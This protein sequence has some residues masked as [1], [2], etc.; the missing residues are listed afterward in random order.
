MAEPQMMMTTTLAVTNAT[1]SKKKRKTPAQPAADH[2]DDAHPK[3]TNAPRVYKKCEHGR[4]KH[5]CRDCRG[6]S[7]CLHNRQK[8]QC[9]PCGGKSICIH[10]RIRS[11]CKDCGGGS[12]CIHNKVKSHCRACGGSKYCEHDKQKHR[13]KECKGLSLCHHGKV[14]YE[15]KACRGFGFCIHNRRKSQC[16]ECSG[17]I[18]CLHSKQKFRCTDCR[19]S[20]ICKHGQEKYRC[21]DCF[22]SSVCREHKMIKKNC[23]SC[24]KRLKCVEPCSNAG[25]LKIQCQFGCNKFLLCTG[26]NTTAVKKYGDRCAA[27]NTEKTRHEYRF[28]AFLREQA[29]AGMIPKYT[30]W[31]CIDRERDVD[32]C[33]NAYRPDFTYVEKEKKG[34][35]VIVEF[36]E[37]QHELYEESCELNRML[38][39]NHSFMTNRAACIRWIRYN[40]D[41]FNVNGGKIRVGAKDRKAYFIQ[42]LKRALD[43]TDYS[44]KIEIEYL[45]YN[46]TPEMDQSDPFNRTE[47]FNDILDYHRW[48]RQRLGETIIIDSGDSI[49]AFVAQQADGIKLKYTE[50]VAKA[51]SSVAMEDDSDGDDDDVESD[52]DV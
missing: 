40:P 27:C 18:F 46:K 49:D 30:S 31:N 25:S 47:S 6:S 43:N 42:R 39:L 52:K 37:R 36:D 1:A 16:R 20:A 11:K 8:S 26:C 28:E 23:T 22:G 48:A 19:G 3:K 41:G 32:Q 12:I 38:M 15:C 24:V 33:S 9:K 35:V 7:V 21:I 50:A 29:D 17:S 2:D 4:Q 45:F 14:K 10:D 51:A 13:C 34:L 5:S 44:H